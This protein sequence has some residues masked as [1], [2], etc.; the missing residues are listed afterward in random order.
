[1]IKKTLLALGFTALGTL[2]GMYATYDP[3]TAAAEPPATVCNQDGTVT[4]STGTPVTSTSTNTSTTTKTHN[5]NSVVTVKE[6][7]KDVTI[8]D[9]FSNNET[10]VLSH[11]L[12]DVNVEVLNGSLN[13]ASVEVV[14]DVVTTVTS[15]LG[16]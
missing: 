1:M 10:H 2:V 6:V 14:D 7:V 4:T 3:V 12:N 8:K 13:G 5:E 16:L 9:N 15:T 11:L